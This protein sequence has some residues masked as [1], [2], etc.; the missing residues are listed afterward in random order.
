[1]VRL[2]FFQPLKETGQIANKKDLSGDLPEGWNRE[3]Y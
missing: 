2:D 3:N 1:L